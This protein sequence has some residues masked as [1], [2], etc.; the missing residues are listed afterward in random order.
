MTAPVLLLLGFGA[1]AQAAKDFKDFKGSKDS[2]LDS[3]SPHGINRHGLLVV[4]N[5]A[6][7]DL[8]H[9]DQELH[10]QIR[11]SPGAPTLH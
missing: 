11:E 9:G 6:K 5:A 3:V 7:Q 1:L 10:C 4:A 8:L 2:K